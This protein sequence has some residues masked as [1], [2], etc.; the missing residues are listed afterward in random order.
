MLLCLAQRIVEIKARKG[1]RS[2][3]FQ[4]FHFRNRKLELKEGGV[5]HIICF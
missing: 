4:T 2:H 1:I 3:Q 5:Y